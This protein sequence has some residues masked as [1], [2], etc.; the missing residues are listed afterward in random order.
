MADTDSDCTSAASVD[1]RMLD[2]DDGP[3]IVMSFADRNSPVRLRQ[4]LPP[5]R[6][7]ADIVVE[8]ASARARNGGQAIS[9]AAGCAACCR[10]L[11]A[12]SITEARQL[13]DLIGELEAPLRERVVRRFAQTV[14]RLRA[15]ALWD[16][17]ASFSKL[18]TQEKVELG[19]DYHRL[20]IACPFL[21][22]ERCS[23]YGERP[24][25][26][27]QYVVTSHPSCCTDPSG[28]AV[29]RV[30]LTLNVFHALT[31]TEVNEGEEPRTVLM[32]CA[33][34]MGSAGEETFE[35]APG[36]FRRFANEARAKRDERVGTP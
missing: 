25:V 17:L 2:G 32:I 29:T 18:S 23:I 3:R 36:W 22:D 7:L 35:T 11:V 13:Q 20:G 1:V 14:S 31:R 26:C 34:E 4:L 9:C 28:G 16:R 19:L 24:L 6:R 27:R 5:L 15:S 12:I 8:N 30:P 10:H 21:E 33:L